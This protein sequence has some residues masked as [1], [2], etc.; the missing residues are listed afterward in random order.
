MCH[1]RTCIPDYWGELSSPLVDV[2]V[3]CV[4][5]DCKDNQAISAIWNGSPSMHESLGWVDAHEEMIVVEAQ[6]VA[7]GSEISNIDGNGGILR[8]QS[9]LSLRRWI[10]YAQCVAQP[11]SGVPYKLAVT[12]LH[13]LL[14]SQ[15][16][17]RPEETSHELKCDML[18]KCT[19]LQQP[20]LRFG[21]RSTWPTNA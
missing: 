12:D 9:D 8:L 5:R 16:N 18:Q 6:M 2:I 1:T 11:S 17:F 7:A 19:S 20:P 21:C 10:K 3:V 15:A 14:D 4:F 13:Q